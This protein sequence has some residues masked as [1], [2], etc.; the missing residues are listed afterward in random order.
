MNDTPSTNTGSNKRRHSR[1]R[2]ETVTC[3][4]GDVTEIS[5]AGMRI[6]CSKKPEN[7]PGEIVVLNVQGV[8]GPFTVKARFAW[9]R[10]QGLFQHVAGFELLD[11][12]ERVRKELL[13][14]ARSAAISEIMGPDGRAFG[15][16]GL[17]LAHGAKLPPRR[18]AS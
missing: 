13:A 1:I 17:R 4:L 14:I 7:K 9:S 11:V 16:N 12:G 6:R 5:A 10:R 2:A 3:Q 15:S 8:N 18:V